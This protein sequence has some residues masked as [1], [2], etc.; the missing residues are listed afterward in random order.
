[1]NKKIKKIVNEVIK[2]LM[3]GGS[4]VDGAPS[5]RG[6]PYGIGAKQQLANTLDPSVQKMEDQEQAEL[7]SNIENQQWG[8]SKWQW[9]KGEPFQDIG[10][11]P[12]HQRDMTSAKRLDPVLDERNDADMQ[13]SDL[14]GMPGMNALETPVQHVPNENLPVTDLRAGSQDGTEDYLIDDI[15]DELETGHGEPGYNKHVRKEG[16]FS[17]GGNATMQMPNH[18]PDPDESDQATDNLG[19]TNQAGAEQSPSGGY[20]AIMAPK[21][22]IPDEVPQESEI[23][24]HDLDGI[25][26]SIDLDQAPELKM[27][28]EAKRSKKKSTRHKDRYGEKEPSA[29][30]V[31]KKFKDARRAIVE[32]GSALGNQGHTD[33]TKFLNILQNMEVFYNADV[34]PMDEEY[35]SKAQQGYFHAMAAE[36][37]PEFK[38]LAHEFDADTSP[39]EFKNL[40][41]RAPKLNS[42]GIKRLVKE[43]ILKQLKDED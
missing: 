34:D 2:E 12:E 8:L 6:G 32:L 16:L 13:Y 42:E 3:G 35:K 41:A 38:K 19:H 7:N 23:L 9:I 14:P 31:S 40:P 26:D 30:Q 15:V 33:V 4:S 21:K 25:A 27:R 11:N 10:G 24:D 20:G 37:D 29:S 28:T 17:G 43:E 36:G 18:Y 1:M 5:F 39:E 22:F